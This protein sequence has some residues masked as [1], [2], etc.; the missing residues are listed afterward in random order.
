[1]RRTTPGDRGNFDVLR[2]CD[3]RVATLVAARG[4]SAPL[5]RLLRYS[6]DVITARWSDLLLRSRRTRDAEDTRRNRDG[7]RAAR[8]GDFADIGDRG[9]S[10]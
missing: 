9:A 7:S 3:R 8:I 4:S 5:D 1:M 10:A 2:R 6:G